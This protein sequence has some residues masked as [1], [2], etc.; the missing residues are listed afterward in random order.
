MIY[1]CAHFLQTH[2]RVHKRIIA[3]NRCVAEIRAVDTEVRPNE[4]LAVL[5][6]TFNRN[7]VGSVGAS[8]QPSGG[9]RGWR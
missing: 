5:R 1:L 3:N 6:R 8:S 7:L 2:R 4:W 9:T